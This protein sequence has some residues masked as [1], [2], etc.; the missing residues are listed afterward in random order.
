MALMHRNWK[1][2]LEQKAVDYKGV[3]RPSSWLNQNL[4]ENDF[5]KKFAFQDFHPK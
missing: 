5:V 4:K 3:N 1:V 2:R